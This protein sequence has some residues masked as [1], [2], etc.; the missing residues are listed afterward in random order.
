MPLYRCFI[1]GENFLL[2]VDGVVEEVGFYTTR[3]V[4]A[5]DPA[6]A[7]LRAIELLK[8]EPRFD[9]PLELRSPRARVSFEEVVPVDPDDV[10]EVVPGVAWYP[11]EE[12]Q[13]RDKS[14]S[15]CKQ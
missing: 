14:E 8:K 6:G 4:E 5:T 9:F 11:M 15:E 13:Q 2:A 7:E 3:W 12:N 10:P 1:H